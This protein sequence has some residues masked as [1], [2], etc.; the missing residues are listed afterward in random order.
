MGTL[1]DIKH[2]TWDNMLGNS[3]SAAETLT[4]I[5]C[6]TDSSI[7]E[8]VVAIVKHI[9]TIGDE[10]TF[11]NLPEKGDAELYADD[12]ANSYY[13]AARQLLKDANR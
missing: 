2:T 6:T 9:N 10:E 3:L 1:S 11:W 12:I 13:Q 5:D 8:V 4:D 7:E